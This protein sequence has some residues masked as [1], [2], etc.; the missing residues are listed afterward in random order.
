MAAS[1]YENQTASDAEGGRDGPAVARREM[2]RR[3]ILADQEAKELRERKSSADGFIEILRF[4]FRLSQSGKIR[5]Q[6]QFRIGLIVTVLCCPLW[7]QPG[8]WDVVLSVLSILIGFSM[9]GFCM[10]CAFG[11]E[12]FRQV[13]APQTPEDTEPP[14]L[15]MTAAFTWFVVLQFLSLTA[16]LLC[17]AW[18][19]PNFYT[20]LCS[21]G[22]DWVDPILTFSSK[23]LWMVAFFLF[24]WSL[25]V[26]L[27]SALY[28]FRLTRMQVK[29]DIHNMKGGPS[30]ISSSSERHENNSVT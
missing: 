15:K 26:G 21:S 25:A 10:V 3:K 22:W 28:L 7:W 8:W 13:M 12:R 19:L 16:A 27:C 23:C 14:Y 24:S 1:D 17:R 20:K 5:N 11:N 4:C 2:A 30:R 29:A 18:Y 9:S 6:V